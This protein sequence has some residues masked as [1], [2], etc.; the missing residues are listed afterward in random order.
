MSHLQLK[1]L[2]APLVE[3]LVV[4]L[5]DEGRLLL[6]LVRGADHVAEV[7]VLEALGLPD[8]VVVG[9]VDAGRHSG[10]GEG[11]DVEGGEVGQQELVLLELLR[12]GE[13]RQ[14]VLGRVNQRL[15]PS[16]IDS[17]DLIDFIYSIE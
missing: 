16:L 5:G 8:L 4:L 6:S 13:P 3:D 10:A 15:Q 2:D 17:L 7:H 12:P 1:Q 9:N 14:D 11:E